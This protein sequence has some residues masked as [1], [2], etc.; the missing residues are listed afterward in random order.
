MDMSEF[1]HEK[2]FAVTGTINV[3]STGDRMLRVLIVDDHDNFR[4][5]LRIRLNSLPFLLVEEAATGSEAMEKTDILL[6]DLIFMD[7]VLPD[8]NGLQITREIKMKYPGIT[9]AIMTNHD[10]PE[11]LESA[12]QS[13]AERFFAKASLE[14]NDVASFLQ[15][16][17]ARKTVISK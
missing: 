4:Q 11:Y 1:G 6:P 5:I 9:I 8:I 15:A 10:R 12:T 14:W 13:G 7:I 17:L 16:L 3:C 2:R